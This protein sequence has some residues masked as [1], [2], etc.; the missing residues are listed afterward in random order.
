MSY[1]LRH[2]EELSVRIGPRGSATPAEAQA[3]EYICGEL[4][5]MGLDTQKEPFKSVTS[6]S[7]PFL[8]IYALF[9]L[10]AAAFLLKPMAGLGLAALGLIL[11]YLESNTFPILS[12]YLPGRPSQN[13]RAVIPARS[14][15]VRRVVV[16]AHYDSSRWGLNFKPGMV[17]SFRSSYLLMFGAMVM[18][19]LLFALGVLLPTPPMII[20]IIALLPALFL[21]ITIGFLIHREIVGRHTHGANDN[22]SGT[23]V[24]LE[25]ARAL[26][27]NPPATIEV[28]IVATGCEEAGTVGMIQ[29]LK[30]HYVPKHTLFINLDN[31][32][33]GKLAVI[34]EEGL[35][36][37]K[38]ASSTLLDAAKESVNIKNLPVD[39]RPYKLLT[40][41][42]TAVMVR[43]YGAVGVMGIDEK[44]LL[45][46]WH[47]VTDTF[48]NVIP[49]N[50]ENARE[51]VLGILREL[52]K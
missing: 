49:E 42:A 20:G 3:A 6:F 22:A 17:E 9:P 26:A 8:I 38:K 16:T 21:L 37:P 36:M 34:T 5:S 30:K 25:V 51:L 41:D 23:A 33:A 50:L 2:L 13:V 43:G 44:G 47:W 19:V 39:F 45:P 10:S 29:Y 4:E 11:F 27:K 12:S 31:L 46:N 52:E 14:K 15:A 40:T 35:L 1:L 32:G 7:W 48:E 24:L 28:E 18:M